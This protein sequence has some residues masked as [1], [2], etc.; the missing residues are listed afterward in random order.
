VKIQLEQA[1]LD[2][3]TARRCRWSH[4]TPLRVSGES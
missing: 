1:E 3:A 2:H 4:R